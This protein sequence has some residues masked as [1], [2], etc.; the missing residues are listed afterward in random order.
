VARVHEINDWS[1]RITCVMHPDAEGIIESPQF[2]G[3]RTELGEPGYVLQT[4][5]KVAI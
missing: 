5:E 3:I 2:G 1:R 4:G